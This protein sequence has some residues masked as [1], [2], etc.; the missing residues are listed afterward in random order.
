[1][2]SS[3]GLIRLKIKMAAKIENGHQDGRQNQVF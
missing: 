1:M 3:F 2:F